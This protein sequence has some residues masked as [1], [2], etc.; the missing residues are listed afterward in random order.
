M[1]L[2][3]AVTNLAEVTRRI[4]RD[5]AGILT[6]KGVASGTITDDTSTL[7][8]AT[9]RPDSVIIPP[10]LASSAVRGSVASI[11]SMIPTR[12]AFEQDL[13]QSM[14]YRRIPRWSKD[15]LSFRSSVLNFHALSFLSSV[16][17]GDIS[18][19]SVIAL[20]IFKSDISNNRHYSFRDGSTLLGFGYPQAQLE[21]PTQALP[22]I[23][24][25]RSPPSPP[26]SPL[27]PRLSRAGL[28]LASPLSKVTTLLGIRKKSEGEIPSSPLSPATPQNTAFEKAG[29]IATFP[30]ALSQALPPVVKSEMPHM[31]HP[32][33]GVLF[34]PQLSQ[35]EGNQADYSLSH[36]PEG[37]PCFGVVGTPEFRDASKV[38]K[39]RSGI[40][41]TNY[42]YRATHK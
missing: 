20:P 18:A 27:T 24:L 42:P 12:F 3:T 40:G 9:V 25:S 5:V 38:Q 39:Y 28:F 7:R 36:H 37:V 17:L 26:D 11:A 23:P 41:L 15:D 30:K 32:T 22:A 35:L 2:S 21:A 33:K 16:S 10:I 8:A 4:A 19:L 13:E 34:I 1:E 29:E 6:A 14:A 31:A